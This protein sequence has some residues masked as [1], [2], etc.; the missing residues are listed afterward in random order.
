MPG[1]TRNSTPA[2][3]AGLRLLEPPAEDERVTPLE[4]GHAVAGQGPFD[5]QRVDA[6]LAGRAAARQLG[7]IHQL[8]VWR[9]LREQLARSQSIGDH[10]VG[11][12]Q[13]SPSGDR[14]QVG[15]AGATAD[16]RDTWASYAVFGRHDL[17]VPQPVH[18]LVAHR[19]GPLRVAAAEHGDGQRAVPTHRRRPRGRRLGV[20]GAD[21]EDAQPLG[22]LGDCFID[23]GFIR[24]AHDVPR[25]VQV[26]LGVTASVPGDVTR[27]VRDPPPP[28][29]SRV[30]PARRRRRPR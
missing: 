2:S 27:R 1:M 23:R 12:L 24:G 14:D 15:V 8:D 19:C 13:R 21:A 29:W 20:V 30:R 4:P 26:T 22:L 16:Q 10:H 28:G 18:D 25:P 3:S 5:H 9:Q 11:L 6:V 7:G 17:P